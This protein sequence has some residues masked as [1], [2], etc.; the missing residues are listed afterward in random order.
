MKYKIE[1]SKNSSRTYEMFRV[2]A[3]DLRGKRIFGADADLTRRMENYD[4][5]NPVWSEWTIN[6]GSTGSQSYED[7]KPYFDAIHVA[8]GILEALSKGQKVSDNGMIG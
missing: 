7:K 4:L 8:M 1:V 2:K 5:D 3:V 6:W